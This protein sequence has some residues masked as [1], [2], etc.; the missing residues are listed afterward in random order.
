LAPSG[1]WVLHRGQICTSKF[2]QCLQKFAS[3]RLGVWQAGQ[4]I[5]TIDYRQNRAKLLSIEFTVSGKLIHI[6]E[7]LKRGWKAGIL[8]KSS[9]F[10]RR[11]QKRY[12]DTVLI[13]SEILLHGNQDNDVSYEQS[14][15]MS[16]VLENRGIENHLIRVMGAGHGFDGDEKDPHVQR[17]FERVG[18]F[19]EIYI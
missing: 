9:E 3:R 7:E 16:T 17:I 5:S 18:K 14:P 1:K 8:E 10:T 12:D 11:S 6:L 13:L 19:L 15:Q 2:P 4:F